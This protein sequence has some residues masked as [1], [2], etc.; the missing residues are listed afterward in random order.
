MPIN[1]THPRLSS[2]I[3]CAALFA[4]CT[5]IPE[6]DGYPIV[7]LSADEIY[8]DY[9]GVTIPRSI[10]PLNFMLTCDSV[11]AVCADFATGDGSFRVASR[12]RKVVID[13]GVWRKILAD[14]SDN[15][16][17]VTLYYRRAGSFLCDTFSFDVSDDLFDPF[18]TYRLIEPGYEVW[19]AIQIEERDMT[20]FDS[21]ILADNRNLGGRCMNCHIHSHDGRTTLFHVRGEGGASLLFHSCGQGGTVDELRK[22]NLR[23]PHMKGG[24]VYGDVS[25]DGHYGVFS[26][27]EIIPLLHS[28]GSRR[29]EVYDAQSDLCIADFD[30][31][32][33]I[34]SPLVSGDST[35]ETFP[36]FSPNADTVY[37]CSAPALPLPDSLACLRYSILRV[38]F[39]RNDSEWAGPID[40]LWSA[41][42]HGMS[43]SFPK[44]SPDGHFLLFSASESGTFPIWHRETDFRMID[45]HTGEEVD[46]SPLNS[47]LS[48]TYHTW[49]RSSRWVVFASKRHDGQYGRVYI[50]HIDAKGHAS[51]PFVLPQADPEHDLLCLKSYNIP[52]VSP[53][54]APF[55]ENDVVSL[56]GN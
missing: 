31:G 21:R 4:A 37:F 3:A 1:N 12:G 56:L 46:V 20:S 8:P 25:S 13:E 34:L 33:M 54:P 16:V 11:D 42:R 32:K 50:A 45:L 47:P 6:G 15:H 30:S 36:C 5:P 14:A 43:A 24:A 35:L 41:S 51:R 17:G 52:D 2:L 10:A 26:T 29:L 55:S 18:V 9:R 44:V 19:N 7:S 40:T 39:N 48:E 38:G 53:A 22:V 49:S 28:Q 23:D 27:N